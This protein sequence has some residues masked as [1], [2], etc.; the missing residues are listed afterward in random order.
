MYGVKLGLGHIA[1]KRYGNVKVRLNS[2]DYTLCMEERAQL[3]VVM[4]LGPKIELYF[5]P[6]TLP[7]NRE[8]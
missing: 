1:L 2:P 7:W 3:Q 4:E 6:V 8:K 5:K